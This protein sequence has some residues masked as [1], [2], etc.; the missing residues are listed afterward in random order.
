VLFV[1]Q[2]GFARC[3][4]LKCEQ[5]GKVFAGKVVAKSS[6]VKPKAKQKVRAIRCV[7]G[8]IVQA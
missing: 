3:Y 5:T 4:E 8:V 1:R 7:L 6:L 2:G